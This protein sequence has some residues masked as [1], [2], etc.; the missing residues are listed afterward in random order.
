MITIVNNKK[1]FIL[2]E[3]IVSVMLLSFVGIALLQINSN[4]K[5]IYTLASKK[6]EFSRYISIVTNRHS[7]D[8]HKRDID[9]YEFVKQKYNIRD[10]ELI[11]ILKETKIK[12]LQEYKSV[13]NLNIQED[14]KPINI[15]IDKIKISNKKATSIYITVKL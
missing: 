15:L 14:E 1:G 7:I 8:L 12:Y 6:L 11:K 13:I 9:L 4:Q 3:I 5:K 10:E 2:V